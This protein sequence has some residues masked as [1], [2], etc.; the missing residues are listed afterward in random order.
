[1]VFSVLLFGQMQIFCQQFGLC[2]DRKD[3]MGR[4][5]FPVIRRRWRHCSTT[6]SL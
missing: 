3:Q 4:H 1:L 6:W 5:R 2:S